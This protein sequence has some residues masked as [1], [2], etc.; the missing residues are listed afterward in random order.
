VVSVRGVVLPV[1]FRSSMRLMFPAVVLVLLLSGVIVR[2]GAA[3]AEPELPRSYIDIT[4]VSPTGRII[5]V[6]A[7]GDFQKALN[8][9][10][11]G[12]T[13]ALQAGAVFRGPFT[14]PNK[15]SGTGWITVRTSVPDGRFPASGTRVTPAQAPL[16]PKLVAAYG[17][18][19]TTAAGAHHYRFIGV[20]ISPVPGVFLYQLVTLASPDGTA[21]GLPHDIIFDRSYLH[22][23]PVKGTRR[24]IA[25]NSGTTAVINS[26]L[27]DFKEV[28][29]DSQAICGWNG[30]GPF[31]IVNNYLEGAGENVMFGGGD[32]SIANLVPSDIEIRRN[33]MAKP[34]T[35]KV[36][37]PSY[38]GAHWTV[39]N[40]FELKNAQRVLVEGNV[41]ENSWLDA[42]NGFAILFT[43]RNQKGR[44]PWSVVQDVTFRNNIVRHAAAGINILG[45]DNLRPSRPTRRIRIS[46]NLLYDLGTAKWGGNGRGFEV[47]THTE[48][49]V[50]I[51]IEHNTAVMTHLTILFSGAAAGPPITFSNNVVGFGNYGVV[52]D[53]GVGFGMSAINHYVPGSVFA[54]NLFVNN[55][56]VDSWPPSNYPGT[57]LFAAGVAAVGFRD[58]ARHDYQL[59]AGSPYRNAA[60]DGTDLGVEYAALKARGLTHEHRFNARGEFA[61]VAAR[62]STSDLRVIVFNWAAPVKPYRLRWHRQTLS[63]AHSP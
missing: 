23:D 19:I 44:A 60:T 2:P 38:A 39:K 31:K 55:A 35:W 40:L 52:G 33:H 41:F 26:Y 32:P 27:A 25:L 4:N 8:A 5:A 10:Q 30:P 11:A 37:D 54:N 6:A 16:M 59:T 21:A 7:G 9:A 24:G 57:S 12:D 15:L 51:V 47:L 46:S 14:L 45:T 61:G 17:S 42:Q 20:E 3:P 58:A 29:A 1:A 28:G 63:Y 13:I 56:R 53:N 34:L 50:D 49:P 48:A 43:P 22:G 36:N 18:V 62:R